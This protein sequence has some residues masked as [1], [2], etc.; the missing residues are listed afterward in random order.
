VQNV[1][2]SVESSQSGSGPTRFKLEPSYRVAQLIAVFTPSKSASVKLRL[3][4]DKITYQLLSADRM[5]HFTDP[6]GDL[7]YAPV[8]LETNAQQ[9]KDIHRLYEGKVTVS[10]D[11]GTLTLTQDSGVLRMTAQP[12]VGG[13]TDDAMAGATTYKV[14]TAMLRTALDFCLPFAPRVQNEA[15]SGLRFHDN[16]LIASDG[17]LAVAI[18]EFT[19]G[20]VSLDFG[21]SRSSAACLRAVLAYTAS[22]VTI[23]VTE[24]FVGISDENCRLRVLNQDTKLPPTRGVLSRLPSA[25][26]RFD[27]RKFS[28]EQAIHQNVLRP[29]RKGRRKDVGTITL[30]YNT[31]EPQN[32]AVRATN[33]SVAGHQSTANWSVLP[34]EGIDSWQARVDLDAVTRIVPLESGRPMSFAPLQGSHRGLWVSQDSDDLKGHVLL[35]ERN[36]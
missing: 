28:T 8:E 20:D 26:V 34:D 21:L 9:I 5:L 22:I 13:P 4:G 3:D 15:A 36:D 27:A 17:E 1:E 2:L 31:T 25:S 12:L 29:P 19:K 23:A 24:T 6:V 30:T 32:V 16:T 35:V 10:Y 7:S 33:R 18:V 11:D 14:P